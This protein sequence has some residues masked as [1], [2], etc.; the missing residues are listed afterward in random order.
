[1]YPVAGTWH[2]KWHYCVVVSFQ[3]MVAGLNG[4]PGAKRVQLVAV[5]LRRDTVLALIH[6]RHMVVPTAVGIRMKRRPAVHLHAQVI[7]V[8]QA[9]RNNAA[10]RGGSTPV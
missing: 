8:Y 3:L 10:H 2:T 4:Q 1:L 9:K 6:H 5:A 7:I